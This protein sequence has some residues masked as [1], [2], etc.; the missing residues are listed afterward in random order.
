VNRDESD[1]PEGEI[2]HIVVAFDASPGSL[3]ALE[4]AA[5]LAEQWKTDLF[6]L[7][8]EDVDLLR[9]A[10]AASAIRLHYPSAKEEPLSLLNMES[11]LR[12]LAERARREL[13]RAA[14]RARVQW[15]FRTVRGRLP[16]EILLAA[17]EAD[18]LSLGA[19]GWS[20]GRGRRLAFA[21]RGAVPGS[22][23]ALASMRQRFSM[24]LPI[25]V[26]YDGSQSAQA[27]LRFATRLAETFR[28]PLTVLLTATSDP[29]DAN[30][31]AEVSRVRARALLQLRLRLIDTTDKSNF[32]R[33]VRSEQGGVLVMSG[34]SALLEEGT[35]GAL[36]RETDKLILIVGGCSGWASPA[37]A[38]T[39]PSGKSR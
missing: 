10:S 27:A 20:R 35:V 9:L 22:R 5:E 3:E 34:K 26:L 18:L 25:L 31:E 17:A 19:A 21:E 29:L 30:L 36:L 38:K 37:A 32:L 39:K 13:I 33:A 11:E 24:A 4:D 14:S 1:S 16:A 15:S 23:S 8:I 28:T 7:F 6:G 2:R 12:A